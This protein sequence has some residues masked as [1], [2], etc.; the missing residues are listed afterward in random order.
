MRL[1]SSE[2][3]IIKSAILKLDPEA[4]IFLFGSRVDD[5]KKGGDIDILIFSSILKIADK[6]KILNDIFKEL[7]EQ[8]IDIVIAKNSSDPFVQMIKKEAIEL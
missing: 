6:A 4:Q 5:Q 8:K 7:E 2:R 1:S 3:S